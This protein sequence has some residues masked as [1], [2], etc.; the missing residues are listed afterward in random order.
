MHACA[1]RSIFRACVASR[2][3]GECKYSFGGSY[4][5][6]TRDSEELSRLRDC[7]SHL[8]A[9]GAVPAYDDLAVSQHH[10]GR[11]L[12]SLLITKPYVAI[13]SPLLG[14]KCR[15]VCSLSNPSSLQPSPSPSPSHRSCFS[16]LFSLPPP[17]TMT[18]DVRA[19]D[20]NFGR[21]A[22]LRSGLALCASLVALCARTAAAVPLGYLVKR[23]DWGIISLGVT[24]ITGVVG[25][26]CSDKLPIPTQ[27]R[28]AGCVAGLAIELFT[29]VGL[30]VFGATQKRA[31]EQDGH[32]FHVENV[33]WHGGLSGLK[34]MHV[35]G[36]LGSEYTHVMTH[37]F[38]D[39]VAH[40][41]YSFDHGNNKH[42]LAVGA[43]HFNETQNR[44]LAARQ[45]EQEQHY[46]QLYASYAWDDDNGDA[47]GKRDASHQHH[48]QDAVNRHYSSSTYKDK[49]FTE[50]AKI[51]VDGQMQTGGMVA[52]TKGTFFNQPGQSQGSANECND[53]LKRAL[54]FDI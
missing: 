32:Q 9:R 34:Q 23:A 36:G 44:P 17:R 46:K 16:S 21:A 52:V 39:A 50:C 54:S 47:N 37:T 4:F 2:R 53:Q 42:T 11:G 22:G 8:F 24:L 41:L 26:A 51:V 45:D 14:Y 3:Q 48:L 38:D 49:H 12:T 28:A 31:M 27:Y 29:G 18:N 30:V 10:D 1:T 5:G 13:A 40:W 7:S 33:H 43:G 25:A 15:A 6:F 19:A 20:G 35:D